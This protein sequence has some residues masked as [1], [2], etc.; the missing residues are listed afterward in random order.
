MEMVFI[1][2]FILDDLVYS[3]IGTNKKGKNHNIEYVNLESSFD[4]ETTSTYYNDNKTA[5]MYVWGFG[6]GDKLVYGR[7]WEQFRQLLENIKDYLGLSEDRRLICYVHNL[8]Y[9]F[10]FMR[11]YFTW[12]DIFS[13]DV[14][15]PIKC[16][17]A[18]GIEFRCSYMLSGLSLDKVADNLIYHKIKKLKGNLDYSLIRHQETFMTTE[19]LEYLKNDIVIVLNYIN[20][21]L[22]QYKHIHK[23]PLT[24]TGRVRTYVKNKCFFTDKNHKKSSKG[25]FLRY[26][27]L[28]E[29]MKLTTSEYKM[30][31]RAF[32]GGFTHGNVNYVEY[33][34]KNVSSIDFTS[35]YPSVM[36]CEKFPMGSGI[37]VDLEDLTKETLE[38]L[39]E[40]FCVAIDCK[41]VNIEPTFFN[42]S[43]L[44]VSK[45]RNVKGEV[46]NNGRIYKA[47]ELETTITD[48]DYNILKQ[49]Y[50]WEQFGISRM[51]IYKKEY[52]PK[53]IIESILDLY[54]DKTTLKG[55]KGKE[56]EYMRSKGMLNSIYG[57]CVTAIVRD[58]IDYIGDTWLH[59]EPDFHEQIEDYNN[60]KMR[61][62]FYAW[63][64]W[65]T[66]YARRNLW[67]GIININD[68]YVYSDTDSIKLLN[69]NEHK[70]FIDYYD[71]WTIEKLKRMCKVYRIDT[72]RLSPLGK[73]IGVWDYEGTSE[74][75]K[76]LGA[77]R[78]IGY[79]NNKLEI[80]IAGLSKKNGRDYMLNKCNNNIDKVFDMFNDDLYIPK[81][82]T[83]KMTHTYI[84]SSMK[85]LVKD[86]TGIQAT[87]KTESGV[88]LENTEFTLSL[89]R[90]FDT[91]LQDLSK[92][93]ILQK[94]TGY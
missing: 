2:D 28:M 80:T 35:S 8:A 51:V 64:V 31:N 52:L 68:D 69:Y 81:N 77:K 58:D 37:E 74:L 9:E 1:D 23:I 36:L 70:D 40:E 45:C 26:K 10:Q 61:F 29:N 84:D 4:I 92:G 7:T 5:F 49:C 59:N 6:I 72:N 62:L 30:L 32:Q 25:K 21:E 94:S 63:G 75:F 85:M 56:Q 83:G 79:K 73:T 42:E 76:T 34:L 47:Q 90:Q 22:M 19:E 88:H 24:N 82:H 44:S 66:A 93:Y 39:M 15:K 14:R 46:V 86:Y 67:L 20:E 78:Y 50:K 55:V 27:K 3:I 38:E 60:S 54:E 43:Y 89:S 57:M 71:E 33:K 18:L 41:F 48:I 17:T 91:F 11:K 12:T 53:S 65:V 16:L 87:V 13:L